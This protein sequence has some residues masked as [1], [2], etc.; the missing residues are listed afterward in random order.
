[1]GHANA[2]GGYEDLPWYISADG[3]NSRELQR[4][5][6]GH[7][8]V[9]MA[10]SDSP[11]LYLEWRVLHGLKVGQVAGPALSTDCCTPAPP[12]EGMEGGVYGWLEARKLVAGAPEPMPFLSTE[13]TIDDYVVVPNC[14]RDAFD[15]A[16]VTLKVRVTRYG[17]SSPAVQAWLAGQDAVFKACHDEGVEMPAMMPNQ[18]GWLRADRAYQSAA[19]ALYNGFNDAAAERFA[20]IAQDRNSPWRPMGL[21][22]QARAIQREALAKPSPATFARSR[23]AIDALVAAPDGTYAKDQARGMLRALAYRD[24]PDRL[25]AELT[26]ELVQTEPTPDIAF[27]FRD[28]FS[29]ARKAADKP[30]IADWI[31]TL[32]GRGV[33]TDVDAEA[34]AGI[35][36]AL[37]HARERWARTHDVAWLIAALALIQPDNPAAK[38]LAGDAARVPA[39]HP[40]WLTAQYHL[41]RLTIAAGEPAV[42]RARLDRIL[43]RKT[44]ASSD[45]YL[46]ASARLQV[47]TG[48]ADFTRLSVRRFHCSQANGCEEAVKG[49]LMPLRKDFGEDARA[50][51]DRMPLSQRIAVSRSANLPA[52]LR[53]DVAL[54]S[55]ARAVHLQDDTAIDGLARALAKLLPQM[56]A[57]WATIAA[58]PP[59][60]AKRYAEFFAMAKIPGLRVDL[61]GYTRPEGG[62]RDFQGYWT[63]WIILPRGRTV[64]SLV[65]PTLGSYEH[66]W[67]NEEL[68][69]DL[70]CMGE[71]GFGA[72]PLRLPDFVAAIQTRAAVE[73]AAFIDG[74]EDR[75]TGVARK[76]PKGSLGVWEELY[77]YARAHPK[78]PRSPETL[79]W[80]IHVT[81]WGPS[82]D[83]LGHRAFSLL[84]ARYPKSSWAKRSPYYYD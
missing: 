28:Y 3:G 66:S 21:Y 84:R 60:P 79:Y 56:K 47:A 46:F 73:R 52:D 38:S 7:L 22:L 35:D 11:L 33:D 15:T 76:L 29:L 10:G 2:S 55:Y 27:A 61:N 26:R 8:G 62:I 5:Y 37:A 81:R 80:L 49:D 45:R 40:G 53:L 17:A 16:I 72:F 48:L 65:P 6:A 57:D 13:R 32:G 82:R 36:N 42:T 23:T 19:L 68:G 77:A 24:Q 43:A 20:D 58:T 69:N 39:D 75:G 59:G 31:D 18:P 30:E 4:L 70:T 64:D 1:M 67:S 25:L 12:T 34:N 14:F 50:V 41:I 71:C 54:T 9:V 74:Y 83:H 78:D 63:D 51:I 44:L